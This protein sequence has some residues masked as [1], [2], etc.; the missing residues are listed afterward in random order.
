VF[1]KDNTLCEPFALAVPP[2][3]LP[4]FQQCQSAFG[5]SQLVLYSNSAGLEQYDP[6]GEEAASL[7]RAFGVHVLR[8]RDKKP[9]GGCQELQEHCG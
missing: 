9:A 5:A 3:L 2:Q 4:S 6:K 1:D 8:H 7:E